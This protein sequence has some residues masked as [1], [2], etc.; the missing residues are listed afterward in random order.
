M[1]RAP[2]TDTEHYEALQRNKDPYPERYMIA[3][4][5]NLHNVLSRYLAK[6]GKHSDLAT[7]PKLKLCQNA[8]K[9]VCKELKKFSKGII[10]SYPEIGQYLLFLST[11][12]SFKILKSS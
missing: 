6:K 3:S 4:L 2:L 8:F 5:R 9:D 1:Q 7:D 12:K 11:I 10:Y